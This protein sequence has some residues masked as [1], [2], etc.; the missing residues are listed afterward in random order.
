VKRRSERSAATVSMKP[1]AAYVD[2]SQM[3]FG[4]R[5]EWAWKV[6]AGKILYLGA[7]Q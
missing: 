6:L 4:E 3:S 7:T 5:C 1:K 2:C